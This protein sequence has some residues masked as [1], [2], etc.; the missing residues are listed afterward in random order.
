MSFSKT[1]LATTLLATAGVAQAEVSANLGVVSNYVFRGVT[2][3]DDTAA[4]QGGVDYNHDSGFYAGTWMSSLDDNSKANAEVDLYAGF[5]GDINDD[6]SYDVNVLYYYY[7]GDSSNSD[8]SEAT[9]GLGYGPFSASISY[10]YWSE[11]DDAPL[12]EGDVYYALSADVPTEVAG[13][14]PSVW[15]GLYSFDA[16]GDNGVDANYTHWGLGMTRDAGDFGSLTF[17]YDQTDGDNDN[18]YT[19]GDPM[20][21]VA[22]VKGF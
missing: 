2:L 7:P 10:T 15:L 12:T 9:A 16:D 11:V 13:F 14:A 8:Y 1:I 5:S 19:D 17:A 3:S 21:S 22:W 20:F 6:F 4:V 18:D